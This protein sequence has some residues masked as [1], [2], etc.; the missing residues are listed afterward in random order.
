MIVTKS[1]DDLSRASVPWTSPPAKL[2]LAARDVHVWRVALDEPREIVDR[3]RQFLSLDELAR[4]DRFHFDKDRRHFIVARGYLRTLLSRYLN[5]FPAEIRFTYAEHGKPELA[6]SMAWELKFN[7]AHSGGLAAFAFTRVGE[8]GVD[9]EH[10]RPEFTGADIARRFFSAREVA[11]LDRLPAAA[12]PN[13]FFNCWT[14]KEAFIKAK[15]I[16]LSLALDQFDVTLAPDEPAA[17]LRTRWDETEASR[18]SL[19][20]LDV[21]PGYVGAV[22]VESHGWELSCWEGPN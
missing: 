6:A 22:A 19:Q 13:A 14:R 20:A 1:S 21:G 12:R 9:L 2:V 11:R 18:W 10:I 15:G 8:I 17:L 3:L 16:G 7:L 5:I 4:A